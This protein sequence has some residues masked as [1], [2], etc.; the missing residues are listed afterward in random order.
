MAHTPST[1]RIGGFYSQALSKI[2]RGF[3]RDLDDARAMVDRGLVEP[4]QLVRFARENAV[5]L[6]RFPAVDR[7]TFLAAVERFVNEA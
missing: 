1:T 3:G 5:E 7:E 2:E 4:D 6:E